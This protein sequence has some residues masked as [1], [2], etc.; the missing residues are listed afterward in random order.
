MLTSMNYNILLLNQFLLPDYQQAKHQNSEVCRR[1]K[2]HLQ[3]RQERRQENNFEIYHFKDKGAGIFMG[4]KYR[5]IG[6]SEKGE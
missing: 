4:D 3:G 2:F 6:G 5:K 1:E